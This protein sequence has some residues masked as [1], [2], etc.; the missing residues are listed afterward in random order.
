M[1][2]EDMDL[3]LLDLLEYAKNLAI[4]KQKGKTAD[5]PFPDE[6]R[7]KFSPR[8]LNAGKSSSNAGDL[9]DDDEAAAASFEP[10][11]GEV[12]SESEQEI[13]NKPAS[14]PA[15]KPVPVPAYVPTPKPQNVK[16][17]KSPAVAKDNEHLASEP[18]KTPVEF[19]RMTSGFQTPTLTTP[20]VTE[21][22]TITLEA[23]NAL[24]SGKSNT[25]PFEQ[26][27]KALTSQVASLVTQV[28]SMVEQIK[29]L[30]HRN[31]ELESQL[32]HSRHC[33]ASLYEQYANNQHSVEYGQK[34]PQPSQ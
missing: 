10:I 16:K 4:V 27:N 32:A 29:S 33:Y 25:D 34:D 5:L 11:D 9:G 13:A 26:Q 21:F 23:Y 15:P 17:E 2:S 31:A 8:I 12:D 14:A 1:N 20:V 19:D 3:A 30:A 7:K 18:P 22:V 28:G 24:L 6:L